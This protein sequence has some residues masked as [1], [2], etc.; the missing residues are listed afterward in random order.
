MWRDYPHSQRKSSGDGLGGDREGRGI[1]QN[2]KKGRR[3]VRLHKIGGLGPFCQLCLFLTLKTDEVSKT[4]L[5]IY[6]I[7]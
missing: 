1:G 4:K 6:S 7:F 5:L 3:E 2:L